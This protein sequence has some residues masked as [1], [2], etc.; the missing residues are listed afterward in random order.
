MGINRKIQLIPI[1]VVSILTIYGHCKKGINCRNNQY[2]F[3]IGIIG[4]PNLDSI[5]INDT[6]WI[7]INESTTLLDDLSGRMIDF[8]GAENLGSVIGFGEIISSTQIRDAAN[9]FKYKLIYG[10][11]TSNV[12]PLRFREYLYTEISGRYRFKLGIVPQKTGVYRF[13]VSDAANVYKKKFDCHY[14]NFHLDFKNTDQHFYLFP[15]GAGTPPGGGS[16]YFKVK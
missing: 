5:N 6:V 11:E 4:Y 15:G 10:T 12:N 2:S 13:T 16:Y 14:A 3:N 1:V 7:E 9:D 8:S